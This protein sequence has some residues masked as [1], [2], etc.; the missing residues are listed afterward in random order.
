V[1]LSGNRPDAGLLKSGGGFQAALARLRAYAL[2][3]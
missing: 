1:R 3:V 2:A